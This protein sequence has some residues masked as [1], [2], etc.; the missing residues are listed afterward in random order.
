MTAGQPGGMSRDEQVWEL[1]VQDRCEEALL[2]CERLEVVRGRLLCRLGRLSEAEEGLKELLDTG[3]AAQ[4]DCLARLQLG[5]CLW[6]QG[7]MDRA[8]EVCQE[9]LERHGQDPD[10]VIPTNRLRHALAVWMD[11]LGREGQPLLLAILETEGREVAEPLELR[12]QVARAWCVLGEMQ[13]YPDRYARS[14]ELCDALLEAHQGETS[15]RA[16]VRVCATLL[17]RAKAASELGL[18]PAPSARQLVER[19]ELV[20]HVPT[21]RQVLAARSLLAG[22]LPPAERAAGLAQILAQESPFELRDTVVLLR[23]QHADALTA[24]GDKD[25]A[26]AAYAELVAWVRE[27]RSPDVRENVA[28]ARLS[29]AMALL[30]RGQPDLAREVMAALASEDGSPL[31]EL[32]RAALEARYYLALEAPAERQLPMLQLIL[33]R[34]GADPTPGLREVLGQV[35][36]QREIRLPNPEGAG[37]YSVLAERYASET[38]PA[39]RLVGATARHL[40]R[41]SWIAEGDQ[42]EARAMATALVRDYASDDD[43]EVRGFV[44]EASRWLRQAETEAPERSWTGAWVLGGIVVALACAAAYVYSRGS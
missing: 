32:R 1:E 34:H 2:L 30:L 39:L 4:V 3:P 36:L 31:V 42:D 29:Y 12:H 15:S 21:R 22:E 6:A 17:I 25:A 5:R 26:L 11:R 13:R 37:G 43:E 20:R 27:D 14:I 7:E 28:D 8:M 44:D 19:G 16:V 18:D 23:H 10:L 33:D 24:M 9:A 38:L 35:Q 41:L 40:A